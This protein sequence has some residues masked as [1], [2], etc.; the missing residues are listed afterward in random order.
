V[1]ADGLGAGHRH[2]AVRPGSF[3]NPIWYVL[4]NE[5]D[6]TDIVHIPW[7]TLPGKVL[8]LSPIGAF[9]SMATTNLAAQEYMEAWHA[10]GGVP[11]GTFKNTTQM[12][13]QA[14]A[15]VIKAR[16]MEA[17]RTRQPI[18]YGKDW[19]Y[20]P[21]TVPALRGAVHRDA[22]AGRDA[23]GCDLRGAAGVDRRRDRRVDVVQ[24]P[25]AA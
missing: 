14:D 3:V 10:T 9:A 2:D 13:D 23:A 24:Q 5:V 1:A 19:D 7:F 25:G 4:G 11:P 22:E 20:S 16:L 15:A 17:I 18:V 8:G 12:V 21:I 6:P